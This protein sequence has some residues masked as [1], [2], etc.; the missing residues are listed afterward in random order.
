M[1]T[2]ISARD[3][4]DLLAKG[5]DRRKLPADAIL[6]PGARDLLWELARD[7][8]AAMESNSTTAPEASVSSGKPLNSTSSLAELEAFFNSPQAVAWKN[9]LCEIGTRMWQRAYVDGNGG[10]MAIRA[11]EDLALCTPAQ[12]SKGSLQPADICLVDFA[13]NQLLGAKRRTSEIAMHGQIF[14]RQPKAMATCHAHPVHA[15]AFAMTGIVPPTGRLPEFEIYCSVALAPYRTTGT[16]EMGT[17]VADLVDVHNTILLANHG[18]VTWG[19]NSLEEAY[20]R[21]EIIETYCRT[22]VAAAQLGRPATTFTGPQMADL[23]RIKQ[24]MGFV[25]PRYGLKETESGDDGDWR[26]GGTG[27]VPAAGR[28]V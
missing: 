10:N 6:T 19:H 7:R 8:S 26:P 21:I 22:L 16:W 24:S 13:G 25:D 3:I 11:G 12:V 28:S 1:S 14:Q 27:P 9:Q 18:V 17:V 5:N 4:K 2:S 23:L 15:T 20:W